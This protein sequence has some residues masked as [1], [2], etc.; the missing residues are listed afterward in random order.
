MQHIARLLPLPA[1]G[2]HYF[3][4]RA[5]TSP[6]TPAIAPYKA[7]VAV[8]LWMATVCNFA[9]WQQVAQL[10]GG[11]GLYGWAF[12]AAFMVAVAAGNTALL[13]L[14]AWGRWLKPAASVLVVTAA[15]GAYFMQA[16][17]ITI[18]PG[19]V[20]NA[21]QTD[22]AETRDLV[23]AKM[24]LSVLAM[25]GPALWW[26]WRQPLRSLPA[27]RQAAHNGLL[28]AAALAVLALSV[29]LV[30]QD[31]ASN[32]RNHKHLRY[33]VNPLNSVYALGHVATQPLRMD[34][35]TIVPIGRDAQLGASYAQQQRPP[36][37]VLVLGETGRSGNFGINGYA[38]N[39]TPELAARQDI[40]SAR[41]AWSCGTSTA[42]SVPCMFSHLGKAGF[43]SRSA[44]FENLLDVLSHAGLAVLWVGNQA[45]CK[46]VCNR[47][48][49]AHAPTQG[50][51]E[52]CQDGEC[53]DT[54]MLQDL[55][56]RIAALPAEKTARGTVVVLHQMGSHGPAYF[57]RSAASRKAFM[58]ECMSIQ[59]QDCTSA[60]VGNAYD[61]SIVETDHLLGQVLQWLQ[62]R[63]GRAD[64]AM[65]Y[66]ADHG[67]S[68]GEN[69]LYLHGLP[70]SLAPDVQKHVPWVAWLSPA[71]QSRNRTSTP[72][73]QKE[74]AQRHITHDAYF[75]SVLGLLD[76]NTS[77]YQAQQDIWN[78]CRQH[79]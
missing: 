16:Y 51:A 64:T 66:V 73:L 7:V 5:T 21:L 62:A 71:M 48:P 29:L 4:H 70:Y 14:V 37:I 72:C 24:L 38:R 2:S 68:L 61:N 56:E 35:H 27:L 22:A 31:F 12:I 67:E 58:P 75:H 17:G 65:L 34:T 33:M 74:W 79:S 6:S 18:D 23:S 41:N 10:P 11:H 69:G 32:M 20:T 50:P 49:N 59:L 60:Q 63:S 28:L 8:A 44:N 19:M 57:K 13:A 36:L 53:L 46:E 39:T 77:V 3:A 52:L 76:V 25:A 15:C 78:T 47:I 43:E 40:I 1:W 9:L 54:T 45:G 55:D 30:Y 26:L 42:A